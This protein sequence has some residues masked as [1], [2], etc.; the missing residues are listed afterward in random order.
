[1]SKISCLYNLTKPRF[2]RCASTCVIGKT[3][4]SKSYLSWV[5]RSV[6]I[7]NSKVSKLVITTIESIA[8]IIKFYTFKDTTSPVVN[9]SLTYPKMGVVILHVRK[10]TSENASMI[11]IPLLFRSGARPYLLP[12]NPLGSTTTSTALTAESP[13]P[14]PRLSLMPAPKAQA[15]N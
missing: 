15:I 7:N 9:G 4:I 12:V 6:V 13:E 1:M 5:Y 10:P 14:S 2:N 8:I 3:C 11:E